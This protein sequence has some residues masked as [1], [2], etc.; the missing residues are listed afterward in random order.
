MK[1]DVSRPRNIIGRGVLL[2]Y[3]VHSLSHSINAAPASSI[4]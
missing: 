1:L 3:L 4:K 2:Y